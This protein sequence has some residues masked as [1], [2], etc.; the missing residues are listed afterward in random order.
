MS[1]FYVSIK[2][3]KYAPTFD[4]KVGNGE[5]EPV[6]ALVGSGA[7]FTALP[8]SLLT[9]LG[10]EPQERVKFKLRDGGSAEYD[11]GT[12]LL[13]IGGEQWPC[14][15]IFGTEGR[16]ILGRTALAAFALKIDADGE[17]L[18]AIEELLLPTV[19]AIE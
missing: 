10:V 4:G 6:S 19:I 7:S 14:P 11:T 18:E 5:L 13:E 16:Y 9:G 12:V 3:G 15:V 17:R 8:E 2:V 1:T